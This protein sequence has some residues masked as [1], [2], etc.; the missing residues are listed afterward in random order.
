MSILMPMEKRNIVAPLQQTSASVLS[1]CLS[2]CIAG[3]L[4]AWYLLPNTVWASV[5]P[6]HLVQEI[7]TR[8]L[9]D[10]DAIVIS[11]FALIISCAFFVWAGKRDRAT[12]PSAPKITLS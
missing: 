6:W 10:T 12:Q 7:T 4:L 2:M 9:Y 3:S 1:T 5:S 11:I 8:T